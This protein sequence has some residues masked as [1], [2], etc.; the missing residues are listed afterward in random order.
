MYVW[1]ALMLSRP[2]VR[3][4]S[5]QYSLLLTV[6]Y[7]ISS[8]VVIYCTKSTKRFVSFLFVRIFSRETSNI[9]YIYSKYTDG[10][11]KLSERVNDI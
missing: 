3:Y 4:I 1:N 7:S 5:T 9:I 8:F 6:S 2:P 10:I 11:Q